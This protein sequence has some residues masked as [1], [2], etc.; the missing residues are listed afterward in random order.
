VKES[1]WLRWVG[2]GLIALAVAGSLASVTAGAATRAWVTRSCTEDS[3]AGKPNARWSEPIDLAEVVL[4]P[5]Y[6]LDAR[7][8]KEGAL[9]GQRLS[10]GLDGDGSSRFLDLPPE[11][12]A[13]GPFGSTVLIGADDGSVSQLQLLDVGRGCAT[14]V[15]TENAV[16]RRATLDPTGN[17]VYEMRVD[18]STRADLGIWARP[19]DG[20][21]PAVPVIE[22][23]A[24]DE[25]FGPTFA[26]EFAWDEDRRQLVVQ[27]CGELACRTRI[28]GPGTT[29]LRL[30]ADPGLA[31]MIGLDGTSL[32]SY[33]ACPGLPCAVLAVD[34]GSGLQTTLTEASFGAVLS[35]VAGVARLVHEAPTA[36]GIGL[37]A[38]TL[39]GGTSVDLGPVADGLRLHPTPNRT[40]DATRIPNGLVLL[41][42]DGRLPAAGP[43]GQV[44]LRQVTDG[45]SVQLDEVTR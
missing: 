14:L 9:E 38:M 5:W 29:D 23:I 45:A 40:G 26:T 6:R 3:N 8:D 2:P 43:R 41:S 42:P 35:H 22:P 24:P 1:R 37:R 21:S 36:T 17:T 34:V 32:I 25:R 12:F 13:A 27:S 11:S 15:A 18:R 30:V 4:Q 16:I 39:P 31:S 20:N 19:I 10:F 44:E 7:L 28:L 33:A